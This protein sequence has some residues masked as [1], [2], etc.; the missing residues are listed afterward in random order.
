MIKEIS[1]INFGTFIL[2][3]KISPSLLKD[4]NSTYERLMKRKKLPVAHKNLVGKIKNEHSLYSAQDT[5]PESAVP[6]LTELDKR[7]NFLSNDALKFFSDVTRQYL[8]MANVER[9]QYRLHS[10]WVNEMREGEYNPIHSHFGTSQTGLASILFLK[11]PKNY[12]DEIA[13]KHEPTNGTVKLMGNGGG[14]F[15]KSLYS[16]HNLQEGDFLLFP[17]DIKHCV[18]PFKGKEKRRTLSANIDVKY[19]DPQ[20]LG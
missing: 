10:A 16:P 5:S 2:R 7:H 6:P 20:Y 12:G 17:F 14:Q 1:R 11:L 15:Y 19:V 9:F 18:Y 3:C 13:N 8:K 4:F